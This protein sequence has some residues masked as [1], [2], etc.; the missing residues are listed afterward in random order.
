[1]KRMLVGIIIVCSLL[2]SAN[3]ATV[4]K[5]LANGLSYTTIARTA[6]IP[7]GAIHAF[8]IN[9]NYY[10]LELAF[11]HNENRPLITVKDLVQKKGAV[12]GINGGFFNP[13]LTPLGLRIRNG[14]IVSPL[15][16]I[17]WW[18]LFIVK[19]KKARIISKKYFVPSRKINF[20][21]QSGPRLIINGRIP[22]L[23]PG[24]ANRSALGITKSGKIIIAV[25]QK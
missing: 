11:T 10:R 3:A 2:A 20:A 8:R 1:M 25:T 19:G 23:K 22:S 16:R 12:V 7:K 21:V 6:G 18:S 15:K 17:T 9:L 5:K 14:K 4:W 13:N 24:V